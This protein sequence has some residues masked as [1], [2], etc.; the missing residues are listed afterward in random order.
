M[1]EKEILQELIK[2]RE[3]QLG[4]LLMELNTK[5]SKELYLRVETTRIRIKGLKAMLD[6]SEAK[7]K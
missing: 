7:R 2:K 1:S 5:P 3:A 4:K 6:S